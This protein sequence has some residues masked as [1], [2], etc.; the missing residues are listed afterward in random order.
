[1]EYL[2][3]RWLQKTR[4]R[5][6]HKVRKAAKKTKCIFPRSEI[7][8][9]G[10]MSLEIQ[11]TCFPETNGKEEEETKINLHG[12]KKKILNLTFS[13]STNIVIRNTLQ[14]ERIWRL[15]SP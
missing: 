12:V 6:S 14:E 15:V 1:M 7:G 8:K 10:C 5:S 13:T 9:I 4:Q 2:E 3:G 11:C